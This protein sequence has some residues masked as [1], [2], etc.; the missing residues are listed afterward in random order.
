M[1]GAETAAIEYVYHV[2][3]TVYTITEYVL[4]R[5]YGYLVALDAE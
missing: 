4:L 5:E 1:I 2:Y 3:T